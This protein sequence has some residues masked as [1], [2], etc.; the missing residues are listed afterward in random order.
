VQETLGRI[1]KRIEGDEKIREKYKIG[2][3]H[4]IEGDTK[5]HSSSRG[6]PR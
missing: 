6:N 3:F 4:K 5:S 2:G 1:A